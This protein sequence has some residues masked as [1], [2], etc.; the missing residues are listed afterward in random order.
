MKRLGKEIEEKIATV[1]TEYEVK[2]SDSWR[3]L[4]D[5]IDS[6]FSALK[7]NLYGIVGE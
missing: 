4:G 5:F 3:T 6:E 7:D 1:T 2:N